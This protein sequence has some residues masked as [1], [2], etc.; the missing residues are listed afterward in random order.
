MAQQQVYNRQKSQM[1]PFTRPNPKLGS[2]SIFNRKEMYHTNDE[3]NT[4]VHLKESD[5]HTLGTKHYNVD[6]DSVQELQDAER[7]SA[8][9]QQ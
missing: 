1:I 9:G 2:S 7:E 8:Q 5:Q 4:F 6:I 3:L